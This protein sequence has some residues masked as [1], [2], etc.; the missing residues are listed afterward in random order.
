MFAIERYERACLWQHILES[1]IEV[2]SPV[3]TR[4]FFRRDALHHG[5]LG[6]GVDNAHFPL[7]PGSIHILNKFKLVSAEIR[8]DENLGFGFQDGRKV[9]REIIR[10]LGWK[11]YLG[12]S[13]Y[14]SAH[15]FGKQFV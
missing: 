8:S 9:F 12:Y 15:F 7:E 10:G 11:R 6:K 13:D 5:K 1:P 3:K 14:L 2:P 4:G